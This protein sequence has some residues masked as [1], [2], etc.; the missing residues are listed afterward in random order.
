M[1]GID[2]YRTNRVESAPPTQVVLMLFQ[3]SVHRLTQAANDL[4]GE[5][6]GEWRGH[7]HHVREIFFELLG[8]LDYDAA[9]EMCANL[10]RL[11]QWAINEL[12]LAGREQSVD[13]VNNVLK[14]ATTLLEGWQAVSN[15]ASDNL[16]GAR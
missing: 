1:R 5:T 15:G 11:Y 10:Q 4:Q 14:V 16:S 3:E 13:R 9:P 6:S 8:G 2:R 12:I 7:I